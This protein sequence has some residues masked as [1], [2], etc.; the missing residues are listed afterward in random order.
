M[1]EIFLG[2]GIGG[3]RLEGHFKMGDV[4]MFNSNY[5]LAGIG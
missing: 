3:S 1:R 4:T 5:T 2:R